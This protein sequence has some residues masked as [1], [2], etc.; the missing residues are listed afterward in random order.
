LAFA[1]RASSVFLNEII[2]GGQG[3][4]N[5]RWMRGVIRHFKGPENHPAWP[6]PPHS[7]CH[8]RRSS[9]DRNPVLMEWLASPSRISPA[10]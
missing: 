8:S 7:R 5:L 4:R 3:S 1:V 10:H 9:H 6:I 2:R